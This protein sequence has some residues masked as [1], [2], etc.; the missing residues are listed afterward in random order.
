MEQKIDLK[1][2]DPFFFRKGPD[3][4]LARITESER[5][6]P[7]LEIWRKGLPQFYLWWK[8][9][10]NVL[11]TVM[12]P[13]EFA[14]NMEASK[15]AE[16]SQGAGLISPMKQASL[17][18]Q[19]RIYRGAKT[20]LGP[21]IFKAWKF[22]RVD[23][24]LSDGF[25]D[26]LTKLPDC[27][28]GPLHVQVDEDLRERV[29]VPFAYF[30][31]IDDTLR[32]REGSKL[33]DIPKMHSIIAEEDA[34]KAK[35]DEEDAKMGEK[36]AALRW[37]I[38]LKL[39]QQNKTKRETKFGI[40]GDARR[41]Y[42]WDPK[43]A[44]H[45][46]FVPG[47]V[48]SDPEKRF[49]DKKDLDEYFMFLRTFGT[50]V[51]QDVDLGGMV[52]QGFILSRDIVDMQKGF[53]SENIA[54][55]ILMRFD[56]LF[57]DRVQSIKVVDDSLL[58]HQFDKK[59]QHFP[60]RPERLAQIIRS[61]ALDIYQQQGIF[62]HTVYVKGGQTL[63]RL[64]S[65]FEDKV[66]Q[67]YNESQF[68]EWKDS[69][70]K[71]P[72]VVGRNTIPFS[73]LFQ[74]PHVRAHLDII[75]SMEFLETVPKSAR[76]L[77]C[78]TETAALETIGNAAIRKTK[79]QVESRRKTYL[80][81]QK[82]KQELNK[83]FCYPPY[84]LVPWG[85]MMH[86]RFRT[87][88]L[89]VK[90]RKLWRQLIGW[91]N[92]M[93][94]MDVKAMVLAIKL[95]EGYRNAYSFSWWRQAAR[96][97]VHQFVQLVNLKVVVGNGQPTQGASTDIDLREK[98][99]RLSEH[100]FSPIRDV[101]TTAIV[102]VYGHAKTAFIK[103]QDHCS[104]TRE[105][106]DLEVLM[107]PLL[108]RTA[109][110]GKLGRQQVS[111]SAGRMRNCLRTCN[112]FDTELSHITTHTHSSKERIAKE[113]LFSLQETVIKHCRLILMAEMNPKR[114]FDTK[115]ARFEREPADQ[116]CWALE[117]WFD[118]DLCRKLKDRMKDMFAY[119]GHFQTVK[120]RIGSMR[121]IS[122]FLNAF[123]SNTP[124]LK[125]EYSWGY[126]GLNVDHLTGKKV[127]KKKISHEVCDYL[128]QHSDL[129]SPGADPSETHMEMVL[130]K[131]RVETLDDDVA[132]ENAGA[133]ASGS[134]SGSAGGAPKAGAQ[135]QAGMA[136]QAGAPG[137]VG[138]VPCSTLFDE[139]D[140]EAM[141]TKCSICTAVVEEIFISEN[142]RRLKNHKNGSTDDDGGMKDGA[143]DTDASKAKSDKSSAG[144]KSSGGS[145]S[146]GDGGDGLEAEVNALALK[147]CDMEMW[148]FNM[149]K[150][151]YI[152][153]WCK[154][155]RERRRANQHLRGEYF[156]AH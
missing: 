124:G 7:I 136:Q 79:T 90:I 80:D 104:S 16:G 131:G 11:Q 87:R 37:A 76:E 122:W 51:V 66:L 62:G 65:S 84:R 47:F 110:F 120:V 152:C 23:T 117:N 29:H 41:L 13:K 53:N 147:I 10:I 27:E 127:T 74:H 49:C 119:M 113:L 93:K 121:P 36:G 98:L 68:A 39:Q 30:A 44:N 26:A 138:G 156:I 81:A 8:L 25:V 132:F 22:G 75:E 5:W 60:G 67:I 129:Q 97:R 20:S 17:L 116:A 21:P 153:V 103:C 85:D 6:N 140:M 137:A 144:S 89:G 82:A 99:Y 145:G 32:I 61:Q 125:G 58:K 83:Q 155:A 139:H 112:N 133:S 1:L 31:P 111:S 45:P 63:P 54:R 148:N 71:H 143:D 50:S 34:E 88:R 4:R 46:T 78:Y 150:Y 134:G 109:P 101:V 151:V 55:M 94:Y 114:K 28:W 2:E 40:Y 18:G 108:A 128:F 70:T 64:G 72:G 135:V 142:L 73:K 12:L 86:P 100:D 92:F 9:S 56:D 42:G 130:D 107:D 15:H 33:V 95:Q 115:K 126:N 52:Q 77:I 141:D 43:H 106:S 149:D 57:S 24:K 123:M 59:T 14:S 154:F 35:E 102:D 91:E 96:K 3:V 118:K 146:S 105:I 69:V 38:R 48:P 19:H